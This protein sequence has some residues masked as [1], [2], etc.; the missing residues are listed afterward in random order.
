MQ[1]NLMQTSSRI[2]ASHLLKITLRE[3]NFI[4]LTESTSLS[5]FIF[6]V[7]KET[8]IMRINLRQT[9]KK[10]LDIRPADEIQLVNHMQLV[11]AWTIKVKRILTHFLEFLCA[12]F[13]SLRETLPVFYK[14]QFA[15][16]FEIFFTSWNLWTAVAV[17]FKHFSP[18]ISFKVYSSEHIL[19]STVVKL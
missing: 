4:D 11:Y 1:N 14:A 17:E 3:L 15:P 19:L 16:I 8:P 5:F 2:P 13:L 7:L 18:S 10:D 12:S 9:R 6:C